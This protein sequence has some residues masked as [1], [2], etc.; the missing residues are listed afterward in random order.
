MLVS[1]IHID[2][3]PSVTTHE[4]I[5]L[6]V[7]HQLSEQP[8]LDVLIVPSAYDMGPILRR[9]DVIEY[10]RSSGRHASWVASNCSGAFVL[11][12][13]GLLDGKQATT[14]AG[15]EVGSHTEEILTSVGFDKDT[16]TALRDQ[17][18]I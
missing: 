11:A 15:G 17:G 10:V 13:A 7:Q 8:S 5:S 18:D 14:W 1:L 4:N 3:K 12:K 2:S 6:N 16:L 9:Q